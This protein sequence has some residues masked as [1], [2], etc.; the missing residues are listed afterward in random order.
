MISRKCGKSPCLS[1]LLT[2]FIRPLYPVLNV[3]KDKISKGGRR[4]LSV[5]EHGELEVETEFGPVKFTKPIAYQEINGKRVD[6]SVEYRVESSE[7]E[8]K[9]SKHKTCNS[10]L[11]STN[12]KSSIQNLSSTSIG[13]HKLEYGFKVASYDKSHDLIIDPLL[14]STFFGGNGDDYGYSITIDSD[15]NIYLTGQTTSPTFPT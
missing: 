14:A 13:D 15:G 12:P 1:L 3:G 11:M 4:G 5:N 9:S 2:C 10:K 8:N 7:A 6:V